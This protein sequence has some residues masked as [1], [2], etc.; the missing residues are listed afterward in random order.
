MKHLLFVVLLTLE[1]VSA[2]LAADTGFEF[3]GVLGGGKDLRVALTEKASGVTQW[4]PVGSRI[5]GYTISEYDAKADEI[6]LSKDGTQTRLG[7]KRSKVTKVEGKISPDVERAI[8]NNLRQLS[9][10]ADQ[11]Y[12]E[13]GKNTA[14]YDDLVGPMKYVTVINPVNGENYRALQFVQ[15]Q[16]FVVT[17]STGHS[18]SYEN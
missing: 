16:R 3:S 17:T 14:T 7:L 18:V 12:L 2:S 8:L 5:A 6:V 9:A 10:A 4:V 13:N 11:Y 1:W 15:G